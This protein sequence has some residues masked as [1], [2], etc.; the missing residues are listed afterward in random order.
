MTKADDAGVNPGG[1][2]R[3]ILPR[4]SLVERDARWARVRATMAHDDIDVI[5]CFSNSSW[6]DWGHS[7][8]RYLSHM[9]GNG[10]P[11]S[12]VFPR[13]GAVTALAAPA[14]T[15]EYWL[16]AQDWVTDARTNFFDMTA[17][18]LDRLDEL[19]L[20]RARRDRGS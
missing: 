3:P 9:G 17:M 5:L 1:Y 14:P 15:S 16:K 19:G 6:W 7:Y 10:S 8:G 12:V 11:F 4:L 20:S 2:P 18:A 13:E